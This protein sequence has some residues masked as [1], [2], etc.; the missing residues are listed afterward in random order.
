VNVVIN[1]KGVNYVLIFISCARFCMINLVYINFINLNLR[2]MKRSLSFS[3][4][5][6][7]L[8]AC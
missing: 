6:L 5:I 4:Q 1:I 7:G 8:V 3:I 2:F